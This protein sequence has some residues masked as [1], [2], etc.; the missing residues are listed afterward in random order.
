[1][2]SDAQSLLCECDVVAMVLLSRIA[3]FS[4]SLALS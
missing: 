1:V 4:T 3:S 2:Q